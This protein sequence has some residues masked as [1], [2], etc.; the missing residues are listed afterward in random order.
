M[1]KLS[2][3]AKKKIADAVKRSWVLRR[4]RLAT[5]KA[6][7]GGTVGAK[8]GAAKGRRRLSVDA[9]RRIAEAVRRSWASRREGQPAGT[10]KLG[11]IARGGSILA[12]VERATNALRSATLEE[13]RPLAGRRDAAVRLD[14]LATLASDLKRL[15]T[16]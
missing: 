2:E 7:E 3:E 16:V 15:I 11:S 1:A 5:A 14:E 12:A 8:R 4:A 9:R 6:S 10:A 13:L